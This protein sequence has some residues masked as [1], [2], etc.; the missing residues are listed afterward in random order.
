M[1]LYTTAEKVRTLSES[2][3]LDIEGHSLTVT[4]SIGATLL[5]SNDT[6]DSLIRRADGL[7]YRSKRTGG[8]RVTVG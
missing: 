5:Y 3:R 4:A 1:T 6:A 8:N 7:M 2:S